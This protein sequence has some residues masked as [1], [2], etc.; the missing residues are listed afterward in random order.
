MC[1]LAAKYLMNEGLKNIFVANRTYERAKLLSESIGGKAVAFESI[2]EL[3]SIVDIVISS[4]SS[5]NYIL[6]Y[7]QIEKKMP[8]RKHRP[9]FFID[10]AVPRDIDPKINEIENV[11]VYD[12]DDLKSVVELNKKMRIRL[13]N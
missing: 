8:I 13:L 1:E 7:G 10:I 11:Y 4:T 6:E 2:N 9:L 3:L 5:N 12:I